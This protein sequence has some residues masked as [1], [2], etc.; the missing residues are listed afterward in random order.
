MFCRDMTM[1]PV[2]S[3]PRRGAKTAAPAA[4]AAANGEVV[5]QEQQI[6]VAE[7]TPSP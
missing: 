3:T 4:D 7:A 2:C 1:H 5:V 6:A